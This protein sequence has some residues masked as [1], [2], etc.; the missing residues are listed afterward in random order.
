MKIALFSDTYLPDINGVATSTHILRNELMKLGHEV[1]V[2]TS[3]LPSDSDY[4]DEYDSNILRVPGLEIQALYG[5]R[6]CNIY[7]FKGMKE[8]KRFRPE[9]IHVQTEFGIGIFG[10]IAGENL[11]VPVVYTYH[12][13]WEDYSHYVNPINSE[14]VDSVV[15]KVITKI[16]KFYGN[17]CEELIVPSKKTKDALM[18]YGLTQKEINISP[19]GLELDRFDVQHKNEQLCQELVQK[20]GLQDKFVL[21]FLGRIAPEKSIEVIIDALKEVVK[22]NDQIRCLIV[23]GGPQLE[24]LKTYVQSDQINDYIIFT[25]PQSGE[26]VPAHYHVSDMFI[27]ASLSE[28]QGLTY[29]EAM[30]SHIPVIARY[31]DQLADVIEDGKNGFFFK[32]K[33]ELPG[34]I[35]KAMS[36]DLSSMKKCA[37]EKAKNFSGETF[38]NKVIEVYHKALLIK[39]YSYVVKSIIPT[40]N[41]KN[42]VVF[43]YDE[44]ESSVS[45]ELTDNIVKD[46]DITIGKQFSREEFDAL[47]DLEQISRAYHKALKYLTVKDYTYHQMKKKLMDKGD[48]DD[49]QLDATLDLLCEKNLINDRL[50]T[51]NY[52]KRCTRLGI[53]LNKAIYNLRNNGVESEII[54]S[55]L[56]DMDEDEYIAATALIDTY[57]RKNNFVSYKSIQ[58]KIREKLYVKGFTT[59]TIERA[60]NDYDFEYDDEKEK[61]ALEKDT[62]KAIV[63]YSKKYSGKELKNKLIDTLLRK[64]YNYEDIK[65]IL[66]AKEDENE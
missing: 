57:F 59:D 50:Y 53:G 20:Y 1:L 4:E 8:I 21:T 49:T 7:S 36:M 32:Q 58:N 25:G 10:R 19:T 65:N 39:N 37:L 12:T 64:G 55:C 46:H 61:I 9:V 14:T 48:F 13:M 16:S 27:S 45:L 47:K 23:G 54:D 17:K 5:Y 63:K 51:I 60:M 31:D 43:S 3:E 6:A 24:E 33:E 35:L 40:K 22:E 34:L 62:S 66:A 42:E 15:K 38:A 52:L 18:H 29:I 56:E 30:A 28:T 44:N 41:M 2:V 11:D 26:F